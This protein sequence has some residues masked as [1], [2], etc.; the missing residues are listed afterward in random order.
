MAIQMPQLKRTPSGL[1]SSRKAKP[2]DL[3]DDYGKREEKPTWPANLSQT[4]ARAAFSAWLATV[5]ERIALIRKQKRGELADLTWRQIQVLA[6]EWYAEQVREY[7]DNPGDEEG[8]EA[9]RDQLSQPDD[10]DAAYEAHLRD[11]P[12]EGGAER[13]PWVVRQVDALLARRVWPQPSEPATASWMSFRTAPAT[14]VDRLCTRH[15]EGVRYDPLASAACVL[16]NGRS[17]GFRLGPLDADQRPDR[18]PG[19]EQ[20]DHGLV[21]WV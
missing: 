7:Q 16:A 5:D 4:D 15:Q 2:P 21:L 12:Y 6:A 11:Q 14:K 8:W 19:N 9:L 17:H 10:P 1:W 3:R 18:A 20:G 13:T